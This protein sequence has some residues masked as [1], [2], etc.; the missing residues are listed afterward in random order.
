LDIILKREK[1][2]TLL[3]A[4]QISVEVPLH[5]F[6]AYRAYASPDADQGLIDALRAASFPGED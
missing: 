5:L 3:R 6:P 2:Q 4:G 1:Y